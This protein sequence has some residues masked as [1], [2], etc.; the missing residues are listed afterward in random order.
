MDE[1][2]GWGVQESSAVV[3]E[4]RELLQAIADENYW[5]AVKVQ[6]HVRMFLAAREADRRRRARE[7]EIAAIFGDLGD[8]FKEQVN[9]SFAHS[10]SMHQ[11]SFSEEHKRLKHIYTD[12][13]ELERAHRVATKVQAYARRF[14]DRRSY[15]TLLKSEMKRMD[16]DGHMY[17]YNEFV[18]LY[19][20]DVEWDEALLA[21]YT[22]DIAVEEAKPR[23]RGR[24]MQRRETR[25]KLGRKQTKRIVRAET[26]SS[27][28]EH[29]RRLSRKF[30]RKPT[31]REMQPKRKRRRY[32]QKIKPSPEE[33]LWAAEEN[34]VE[35]IQVLPNYMLARLTCKP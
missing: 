24:T 23:R 18:D 1:A 25:R 11:S 35:T 19:G 27:E 14:L 28:D 21:T 32:G 34:D 10:D 17:T 3:I 13:E 9:T 16:T 15:L 5:A 29:K 6:T 30:T 7:A 2:L 4:A 20:G 33:L 8:A 12:D 31:V 22:P 26:T